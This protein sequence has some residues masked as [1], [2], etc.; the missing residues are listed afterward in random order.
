MCGTSILYEYAREGR[1]EKD[2][3]TN[4]VD[5]VLQDNEKND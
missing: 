3:V 1:T 4:S 2:K 5:N